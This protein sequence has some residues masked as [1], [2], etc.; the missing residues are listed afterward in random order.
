VLQFDPEVA[1]L[2]RERTWHPLQTIDKLV[3]GGLLLTVRV[4][5]PR[6]MRLWIHRCGAEAKGWEP[7]ELRNELA[8]QIRWMAER[9]QVSAG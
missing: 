3:G 5:D 6:E 7:P 2:M 8:E 4:S 9:Y 1:A